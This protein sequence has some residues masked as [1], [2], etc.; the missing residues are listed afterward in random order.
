[1]SRV[2][3]AAGIEIDLSPE[4]VPLAGVNVPLVNAWAQ[5]R[6]AVAEWWLAGSSWVVLLFRLWREDK[7]ELAARRGDFEAELKLLRIPIPERVSHNFD[8]PGPYSRLYYRP[9]ETMFFDVH[10]RRKAEAEPDPQPQP[11]VTTSPATVSP[12]T[13]PARAP[14]R[15][16]RQERRVECIYKNEEAIGWSSTEAYDALKAAREAYFGREDAPATT[17][18]LTLDRRDRQLAEAWQAAQE[19]RRTPQTPIREILRRVRA[20]R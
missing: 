6:R 5:H 16:G 4:W 13:K 11:A 8:G 9:L 1:M 15:P 12:S 10:L 18:E 14:Q 20:R 7:I 19:L 17:A 3:I 2:A